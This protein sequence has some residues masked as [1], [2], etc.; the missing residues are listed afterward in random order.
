[1]TRE[2]AFAHLRITDEEDAEDAC[3]ALLFE[4]R[5]FFLSRPAFLK[6]FEGKWKKLEQIREAYISLGFE[7]PSSPET[8]EVEFD[9]SDNLTEHFGR[10]H[11]AKNQ[12]KKQVSMAYTVETLRKASLRLIAVERTFAEPFS[13]FPDWTEDAVTIGKEPDPMELLALFKEQAAL[14]RTTLPELVAAK[15]ELPQELLRA[16][17]R[18]S[19]LKNYLY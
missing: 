12:L 15:N 6:T 18:L 13:A 11:A 7:E 8:A 4:H 10:Y 17:K 16:L 2:E 9:A 3:E 1:M 5:Q 19:L 14:G